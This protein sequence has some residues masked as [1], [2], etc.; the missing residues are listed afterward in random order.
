MVTCEKYNQGYFG[1]SIQVIEINRLWSGDTIQ[2]Y[3]L[4]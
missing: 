1:V 2:P 3:L 4:Y